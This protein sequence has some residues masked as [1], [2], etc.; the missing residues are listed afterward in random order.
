MI[1]CFQSN[2][3]TYDHFDLDILHSHI[4]TKCERLA[5]KINTKTYKELGKIQRDRDCN[6]ITTSI[7]IINNVYM[8]I[9]Y[10][11][12]IGINYYLK[13]RQPRVL[14]WVSLA[15]SN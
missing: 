3:V 7:Y 9:V 6:F 11:H 5:I 4:F 2:N 10:Y 1:T 12:S 14:H 13:S 8:N 15:T